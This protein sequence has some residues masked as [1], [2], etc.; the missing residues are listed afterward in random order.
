MGFYNR[1]AEAG[2]KESTAWRTEAK[3]VENKFLGESCDT[4]QATEQTNQFLGR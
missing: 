1:I 3:E 2:D 4:Q